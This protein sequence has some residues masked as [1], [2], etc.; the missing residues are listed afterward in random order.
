MQIEAP[1]IYHGDEPNADLFYTV[2]KM[3]TDKKLTLQLMPTVLPPKKAPAG[4][5]PPTAGHSAWSR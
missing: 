5:T 2:A 3:G 1:F 4:A